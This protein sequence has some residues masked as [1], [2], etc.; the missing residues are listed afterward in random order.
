[1]GAG[2]HSGIYYEYIPVDGQYVWQATKRRHW[3]GPTK[4]EVTLVWL[5]GCDNYN[6]NPKFD[7]NKQAEI[8]AT[9]D[10]L[11]GEDKGG[12]Q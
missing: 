12:E 2:Y 1:M 7:K 10:A 6:R 9:V 3:L 5:I 4:A 8:Q 11:V